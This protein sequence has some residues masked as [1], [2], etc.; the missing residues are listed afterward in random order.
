VT[1]GASRLDRPALAPFEDWAATCNTL[2]LHTQILGKVAL[3]LAR[4][5]PQFQHAALRLTARG[6]ET[7]PLPAPNGSGSLVLALDL[8]QHEVLVDH[9]NGLADR[10]PLTP[11][12]SVAEITRA[13]LAALG[14][15]AGDV[16]ITM[17]PQE[18][19]WQTPLDQDT[20]HATYEPAQVEAYFQAATRAA[21]VLA[22]FRAPYR[23]RA[24]PVN[25]WWGSFDLAVSL[26]SG[27]TADPPADDFLSRNAGNVEQ[28]EVGWWPGDHRYGRAAFFAYAHPAPP[29]LDT[30]DASPGRWSAE[31][32]EFVLDWDDV[33]ASPDPRA[34]ALRFSGAFAQEALSRAGWEPH[35]AASLEGIPPPIA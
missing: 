6:W 12:R 13:V 7:A 30:I 18:V 3:A 26:F 2:H 20:E 25:A 32:G 14:G 19:P 34:A 16:T 24:T 21:Q 1:T 8:R 35:L 10:I 22:E 17:A 33:I 5:E 23:G 15:C 29:G 27:R 11:H 31:L 28:I 9:C 4:P